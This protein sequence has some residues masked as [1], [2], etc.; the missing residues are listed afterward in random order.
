MSARWRS[1]SVGYLNL[2]PPVL[3][4]LADQDRLHEEAFRERQQLAECLL[5]VLLDF[6]GAPP[7]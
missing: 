5:G 2:C 6:G 7:E 3:L 1:E 4:P